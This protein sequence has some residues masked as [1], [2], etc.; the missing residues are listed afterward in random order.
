MVALEETSMLYRV[1]F[2][3]FACCIS[4]SAC[5]PSVQVMDEGRFVTM[6]RRMPQEL[7]AR[8]L[9][10]SSRSYQPAAFDANSPYGKIL[11]SLLSPAF[12]ADVAL[13]PP[14]MDF[15]LMAA[16]GRVQKTIKLCHSITPLRITTKM[17]AKWIGKER[18]LRMA[19]FLSC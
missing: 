13:V 14:A 2:L 9:L 5:A 16:G 6:A 8:G 17:I 1:F 18:Q 7:Q 11:F 3:A 12:I 15:T 10:D 19:Y 4:L